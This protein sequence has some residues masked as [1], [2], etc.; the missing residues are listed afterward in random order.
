MNF[1]IFCG[2]PAAHP[3][4]KEGAYRYMTGIYSGC[5]IFCMYAPLYLTVKVVRMLYNI[6]N[7]PAC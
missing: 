7:E 3:F 2:T 5:P 4:T 1:K 6:N